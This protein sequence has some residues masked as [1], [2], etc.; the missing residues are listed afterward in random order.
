MKILVEKLKILFQVC[1]YGLAAF[2][3]IMLCAYALCSIIPE[4]DYIPMAAIMQSLIYVGGLVFA[5]LVSLTDFI[6]VKI[7]EK[8]RFGM[9]FII[10]YVLGITCFQLNAPNRPFDGIQ[11]FVAFSVWILFMS[12]L[13]FGVWLLYQYS[14]NKKYNECL[15]NYQNNLTKSGFPHNTEQ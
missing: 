9:F 13:A 5:I 15:I 11:Y 2:G 3:G 14:F 6:F 12:S 7:G 4:R 10:I 8:V 1:M